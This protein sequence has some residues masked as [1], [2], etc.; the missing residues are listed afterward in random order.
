[1]NIQTYPRMAFFTLAISVTAVGVVT[2]TRS[3][4]QE[5]SSTLTKLKPTVPQ[6]IVAETLNDTTTIWAAPADRTDA[7]RV[8]YKFSHADGWDGSF[9]ISPN[10]TKIAFISVLEAAH[11]RPLRT[12]LSVIDTRTG[13]PH[14]LDD[15]VNLYVSPIWALDG[16]TVVY[17]K[18]GVGD[19][20]TVSV[21]SIG[22]NGKRRKLLFTRV[23]YNV[24]P[25]G[26]IERKH[27]LGY[28]EVT[29]TA[30]QLVAFDT[31]TKRVTIIKDFAP[32]EPPDV[33]TLSPAGDR[34]LY[35]TLTGAGKVQVVRILTLATRQEE[36]AYTGGEHENILG[37]T[38]SYDGEKVLFATNDGTSKARLNLLGTAD[39][40]I[41]RIAAP[42]EGVDIPTSQSPDSRYV[43]GRH[44]A[45]A[46]DNLV[47]LRADGSERTE[48]ASPGWLQFIGW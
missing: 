46:S 18:V 12:Q 48:I 30:K 35:K 45:T 20:A 9:T 26:W 34:I 6:L 2:L 44:H 19:P 38:W 14:A 23:A 24:I 42:S 39:R 8:I 1:M 4:A 15:D 28:Y 27:V 7:R 43:V 21:Y 36:T 3:V 17:Q 32:T 37:S 25:L 31:N 22:T 41:R 10:H 33:P 5:T 11:D 13:T 29:T 47:L 16:K 40:K